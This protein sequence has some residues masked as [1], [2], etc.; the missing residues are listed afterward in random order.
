MP[1]LPEVETVVRGLRPDVVGR[2]F[3]G[4]DVAWPREITGMTHQ[5]FAARL[6]GQRVE[7]LDRRGK[8]VVFRLSADFLLVHLKMTGRL[9]VARPGQA[10]GGDDRWVRVTLPM[11]DGRELRFSD[12]RK[13]GRMTLAARLE[14]VTGALGPEPL[15]KAFTLKAF[16]ARIA[17]R[18]GALKPLLLNQ[19]FLAGV[20][21]IYGIR[22]EGASVNWYRKP[23]G[24][25]G[26]SQNHFNVYGRE[27]EPCSR[28][29]TPI[30]KIW[31]AQRGTHFCPHCQ[32]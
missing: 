11:D 26:D 3:T 25:E 32:Y 30:R 7:S 23:D 22:Y 15:E 13:F 10:V 28:C 4:A 8:Y 19:A 1:E 20:G 9:Y 17:G 21:N 12:S 18:D 14:D 24:S 31:L 16:R 6:A 29:G 27:D 2:T 5:A